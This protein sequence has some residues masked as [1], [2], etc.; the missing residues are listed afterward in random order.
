MSTST[1]TRDHLHFVSFNSNQTN[2]I[3]ITLVMPLSHQRIKE[4]WA[5]PKHDN[6]QNELTELPATYAAL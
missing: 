5:V 2:I 1:S 3:D 4:M 6:Y